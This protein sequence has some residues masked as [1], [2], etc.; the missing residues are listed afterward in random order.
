MKKFE[1]SY[2]DDD[3]DMHFIHIYD[4]DIVS[5]CERVLFR[6][7][8]VEELKAGAQGNFFILGWINT[9][10]TIHVSPYEPSSHCELPSGERRTIK[11]NPILE[12]LV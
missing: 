5:A 10:F 2:V 7:V 3:L 11:V 1:F 12:G 4:E 9:N 6:P 8:N